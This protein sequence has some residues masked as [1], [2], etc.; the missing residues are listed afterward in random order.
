MRGPTLPAVAA[1]SQVAPRAACSIRLVERGDG[2]GWA[3]PG[4]VEPGED[5]AD[6]AVRELRDETGLQLPGAE[7]GWEV[8]SPVYV[9]DLRASDE[10]WI[11]T[12]ACSV[13]LGRY[14]DPAL[15]PAVAG[16]DDA[17]RAAWIRADSYHD[18]TGH[19]ALAYDARVFPAHEHLLRNVID[20][21]PTECPN[22]GAPTG[23]QPC[24]IGYSGG[25]SCAAVL[26]AETTVPGPALPAMGASGAQLIKHATSD[27]ADRS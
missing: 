18:L 27:E 21:D 4:M 8:A 3:L 15:L 26:A 5:P 7:W 1:C 20:V 17:D 25:P 11:V 23:G 9:P 2:H 22:C 24:T 16:G 13:W 14:S 12:V 10:A 6:A 19:L